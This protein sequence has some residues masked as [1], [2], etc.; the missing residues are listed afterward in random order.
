[1]KKVA[2]VLKAGLLDLNAIG[3]GAGEFSV[4][5]AHPVHGRKFG[6]MPGL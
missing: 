4:L 6:N 3:I 5:G 2:L 1:M